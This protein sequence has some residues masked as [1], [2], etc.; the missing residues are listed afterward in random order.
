[1]AVLLRFLRYF[2]KYTLHLIIL[3][4]G[5]IISGVFKLRIPM[6]IN[7]I[8]DEVIGSGDFNQLI[9]MCS[10]V[11]FVTGISICG[12][13][14]YRY[15][16][17]YIGSNI[18]FNV[19]EDLF[20]SI[21]RKSFSFYDRTKTGQILSRATGDIEAVRRFI[22]FG[23]GE[24]ASGIF[25]TSLIVI[26][27]SELNHQLRSLVIL[28]VIPLFI[29]AFIFSRKQQ[30]LWVNIREKFASITENIRENLVGLQL[31]RS[32]NRE[33]YEI[34]KFNNI[35]QDFSE[36]NLDMAQTRAAFIPLM[37][38]IVSIG[39]ATVFLYGGRL[40]MS[41]E[42]LINELVE[43]YVLLILL[44]LPVRLMGFNLSMAL[45]ASAGLARVFELMDIK[46]EVS[47]N[48][49]PVELNDPDGDIEFD[50]VSFG[51]DDGSSILKNI[52]LKITP[53]ETIG[54]IGATGSGKTTLIGLIPRFYDIDKGSIKIDNVNVKDIA[55]NSLRS[56]IGVVNQDA[57]LFSS[58]IRKNISLGSRNVPLD[59]IVRVAKLAHIHDFISSLKDGY[60]TVVGERGVTLSGGQ[61]QRLSIARAL[62]ID[63]AILIFD[64]STSNVDVDTEE[65]IQDSLKS[66]IENKTTIIIT[67]RISAIR[68]VDRIIVLDEGELVESGSHD[69]LLALNGIY[70]RIYN[71]QL[72]LNE[73]NLLH[74]DLRGA[75]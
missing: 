25:L 21:Q 10:T 57:F 18:V 45:N 42:L 7:S 55:L 61:K 70:S 47:D 37:P 9:F 19:R 43:A 29:V 12:D 64:D 4:F 15:G 32:Y 41:G 17:Q 20:L 72:H 53:G 52:D 71:S 62:L 56:M 8:I 60:D 48:E 35:N 5:V 75:E 67:Q 58:T 27:L 23:L 31:V 44:V 73:S 69:E 30:P 51:Y 28:T 1:M 49:N 38:L 33:D 50:N 16:S 74:N 34:Q 13:F 65:K 68:L 59:D 14:I 54:I 26:R 63:P 22:A 2:P 36:A 66:V 40:V 39:T 6:I 3:L 11:I 24:M 46:E